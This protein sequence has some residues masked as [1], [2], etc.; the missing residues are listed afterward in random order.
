MGDVGGVAGGIEL[1]QQVAGLDRLA[2]AHMDGLDH[3]GLE[4][5]DHLVAAMDDDL[6][7]R[8]R[9][10]VDLAEKRPR[11]A[12]AEY[13]DDHRAERAADRRGRRLDDFQ[14][15]RQEFGFD[16]VA[17]ARRGEAEQPLQQQ[18]RPLGLAAQPDEQAA[19]GR[20]NEFNGRLHGDPTACC[21]GWRNGPG[22]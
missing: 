4:R 11:Q 8:G 13:Q 22:S 1:D 15:G 16:A 18:E 20:R 6:A 21:T 10:D 2:V 17:A 3:P 7:R 12:D 5:L 14:C 19:A 9:H